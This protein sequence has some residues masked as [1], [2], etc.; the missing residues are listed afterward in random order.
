MYIGRFM[1][2]VGPGEIEGSE[3]GVVKDGGERA[4]RFAE[5]VE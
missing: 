5:E 4:R 2:G 3:D 1:T